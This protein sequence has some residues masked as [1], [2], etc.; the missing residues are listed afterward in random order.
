MYASEALAGSKKWRQQEL[1]LNVDLLSGV[2]STGNQWLLVLEK[3]II[4][5]TIFPHKIVDMYYITYLPFISSTSMEILS[6]T[7]VN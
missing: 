4:L 6:L 1:P 2:L 7:T 3:N 5:Y